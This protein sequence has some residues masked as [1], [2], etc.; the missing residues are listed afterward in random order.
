MMKKFNINNIKFKYLSE[1][2]TYEDFLNMQTNVIFEKEF[3]DTYNIQN[4]TI[5]FVYK[6]KINIDKF[7]QRKVKNSIIYIYINNTYVDKL[8]ATEMEIFSYPE[9]ISYLIK[10]C[11]NDYVP[12]FYKQNKLQMTM[13]DFGL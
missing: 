2:I 11:P 8:I 3:D 12:E 10:I 13:G 9:F 5:S 7:Q 4:E 1:F 6:N